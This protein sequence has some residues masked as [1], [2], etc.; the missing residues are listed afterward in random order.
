LPAHG[1]VA[2]EDVQ[3]RSH[4]EL[5]VIHDRAPEVIRPGPQ[6]QLAVHVAARLHVG[7]LEDAVAADAPHAQV[8]RV[9][10]AVDE[11]DDDAPRL[12][13]AARE[14]VAVLDRDD[15]DARGR[16][17]L[18][19]H[20]TSVGRVKDDAFGITVAASTPNHCSSSAA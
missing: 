8:V 3:R 5:S 16:R 18:R 13:V 12:H 6:L 10:A 1:A 19:D 11:L 20:A 4:P 7:K 9:L 14:A 17:S 2:A 15:L